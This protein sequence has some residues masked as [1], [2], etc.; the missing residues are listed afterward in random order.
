METETMM[1]FKEWLTEVKMIL[2]LNTLNED[3]EKLFKDY[4]E[5][6]CHPQT[7]A[8]RFRELVKGF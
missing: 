3:E 5:R 2:A 1:D 7:A 4:F 6:G 8:Y